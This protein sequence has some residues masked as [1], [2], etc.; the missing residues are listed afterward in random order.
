MQKVYQSV[1]FV[2]KTSIKFL[3]KLVLGTLLGPNEIG[4]LLIKGPQVMKGYGNAPE[5]NQRVFSDGWLRTGDLVYYNEDGRIFVKDRLKEVI[6]V[7]N[8][9]I[10]F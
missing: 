5:E 10:I 6:K 3:R 9:F 8:I 7:L 2:T 4:E 1:Y